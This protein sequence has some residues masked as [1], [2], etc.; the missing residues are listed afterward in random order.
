MDADLGAARVVVVP[1]T[2]ASIAREPGGV[3][4]RVERAYVE[5]ARSGYRGPSP[6]RQEPHSR[7][8]PDQ[9]SID[10]EVTSRVRSQFGLSLSVDPQACLRHDVRRDL[11]AT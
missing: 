7:E 6:P 3:L 11:S 2:H 5:A 4:Q 9:R 1:V 10:P 8:H